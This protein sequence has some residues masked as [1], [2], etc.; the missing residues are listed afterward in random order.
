MSKRHP[1]CTYYNE[2]FNPDSLLVISES[3]NEE[4]DS[5]ISSI[6]SDATTIICRI[7]SNYECECECPHNNPE[8]DKNNEPENNEP[9]NNE[10]ENN[11]YDNM[12]DID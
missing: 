3:S 8:L 11:E 7:C 6:T 12:E 1:N 4:G 10:P 9:E 2:L 5:D